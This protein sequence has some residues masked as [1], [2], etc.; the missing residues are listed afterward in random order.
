MMMMMMMMMIMVKVYY[1]DCSLA[2]KVMF[3]KEVISCDVSPVAMFFYVSDQGLADIH[4]LM[5]LIRGNP[6]NCFCHDHAC[7]KTAWECHE[8]KTNSVLHEK[9]PRN[10]Y[11]HSTTVSGNQNNFETFQSSQLSEQR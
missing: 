2:M 3:V 5:P 8:V 7:V 11:A 6:K 4:L 1:V 9:L 10:L